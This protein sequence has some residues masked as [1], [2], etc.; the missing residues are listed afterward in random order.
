MCVCWQS[1]RKGSGCSSYWKICKVREQ[2]ELQALGDTRCG[3]AEV[4]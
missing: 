4:S 3:V 1:C 2:G